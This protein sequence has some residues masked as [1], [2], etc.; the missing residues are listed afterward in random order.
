MKNSL[1]EVPDEEYAFWE[2]VGE[3]RE[4]AQRETRGKH[5][6]VEEDVPSDEEEE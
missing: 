2:E 5:K 4:A 1:I 6:T 3:R